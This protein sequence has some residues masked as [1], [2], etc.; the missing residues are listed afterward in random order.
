MSYVGFAS[1]RS[2]G[3]CIARHCAGRKIASATPSPGR[4][5]ATRIAATCYCIGFIEQ[6]EDFRITESGPRPA[7][8]RLTMK[9]IE[10]ME[11]RRGSR[12]P[13]ARSFAARRAFRRARGSRPSATPPAPAAARGDRAPKDHAPRA[14]ECAR[15]RAAGK[16]RH[17]EITTVASPASRSARAVARCPAGEKLTYRYTAEE[18]G[19]KLHRYWTDAC[20]ICPIKAQCATGRERRITALGV[21]GGC[22]G[23]AE[24][25]EKNLDAMRARH[26]TVE[27]PFCTMTMRMGLSTS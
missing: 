27:H 23:R 2:P 17:A 18:H 21:R 15:G 12:C 8:Y 20:Q 1:G 10:P 13:A 9:W 26:E 14:L 3:S 6:V 4:R 25:L 7:R 19:P 24:R 16:L 22:R 5:S 11:Q